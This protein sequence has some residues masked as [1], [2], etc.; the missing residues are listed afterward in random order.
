[1]RPKDGQKT[2]FAVTDSLIGIKYNLLI[3]CRLQEMN[4]SINGVHSL[5]GV[6]WSCF[7]RRNRENGPGNRDRGTRS[8]IV[9]IR[10]W[11]VVIKGLGF[12]TTSI[13]RRGWK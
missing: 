3:P 6:G 7:G 11:T 4:G 12:A 1:M 13:V 8:A 9:F 5:G 10:V 2:Q